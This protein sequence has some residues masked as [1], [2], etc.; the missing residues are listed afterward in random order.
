MNFEEDTNNQS[1]TAPKSSKAMKGPGSGRASLTALVGLAKI[2]GSGV[3]AWPLFSSVQAFS[4]LSP[5][6]P[7]SS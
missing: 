5:G 2:T 7:L 4:E 6:G 1:I 3:R